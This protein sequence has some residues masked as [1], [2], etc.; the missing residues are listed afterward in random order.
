M[1][2]IELKL[3]LEL[4]VADF[5]NI[6]LSFIQIN[7]NIYSDSL[8]LRKIRTLLHLILSYQTQTVQNY[9]YKKLKW[10]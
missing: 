6:L 1:L 2:I 8:E 7:K 10:W 3:N 9:F 5:K 4:N